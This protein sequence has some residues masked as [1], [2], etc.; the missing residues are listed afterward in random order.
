MANELAQKQ[1]LDLMLKSD[2]IK[3]RFEEMLGK[4]AA[5]FISSI[6]SAVSTNPRLKDC[7][8]MSIIAS[9]AVAASLD[10][11]INPNLGF[12]HIVPYSGRG[13]FQLGWR[14]FVQLALRTA[15]YETI[16]VSEV[17]EDELESWNPLTGIF[18]STPQE[19]WKMRQKGDSNDIIGYVAFFQLLNGFK[20]YNYMTVEQIATHGKRYSKAYASADGQWRN[21]F[22]SM[23]KKT[24]LK[25]L[26]SK[27]GILS[28]EME[29]AIQ[30]DQAVVKEDGT[31]EYSD[32]T[33]TEAPAQITR[34]RGRPKG[35][36]Q[37]ETNES[38]PKNDPPG[39]V[40][41]PKKY[42]EWDIEPKFIREIVV[43]EKPERVECTV[44]L[45][46]GT[47][48]HSDCTE[49]IVGDLENE[50]MAVA[51]YVKEMPKIKN[52]SKISIKG[53]LMKEGQ[54]D[55][56]DAEEVKVCQ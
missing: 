9:A 49:L 53:M 5:G 18:S 29:T 15:Q 14:G 36:K 16:H 54:E 31:L 6:I 13:Q 8:P 7:D 21:N 11:P 56:Y 22:D 44:G 17:Y 33:Q 28:S 23:A 50:E 55:T 12:A 25:L 40:E 52:G 4:K 2:S 35:S 43:M 3:K 24:V 34:P 27:F 20:K 32:S 1:G 48:K 39:N 46:L 37:A 38:T 42:K 10:L 19:N 41:Q 26:L 30:T 47:T 51:V 45:L